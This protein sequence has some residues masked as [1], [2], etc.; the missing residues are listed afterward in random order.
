MCPFE[1]TIKKETINKQLIYLDQLK[2]K[3]NNQFLLLWSKRHCSYG[4]RRR[5][6][7]RGSA[8][9][10]TALHYAPP[11][12]VPHGN[13]INTFYISISNLC[14]YLYMLSTYDTTAVWQTNIR[15]S[16]IFCTYS[17]FVECQ[18]EKTLRVR[19]GY[20]KN[21]HHK[22]SNRFSSLPALFD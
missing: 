6:Q 10:R 7:R 11:A 16:V 17:T 3:Y 15:I 12:T 18:S 5:K 8:R 21:N 20:E 13:C 1:Y 4:G 22:T 14:L 19:H 9:G 2:I